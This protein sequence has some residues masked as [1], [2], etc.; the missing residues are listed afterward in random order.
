[1]IYTA[2]GNTSNQD[3]VVRGRYPKVWRAERRRPFE[4]L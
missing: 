2:A 4:A 1:L 3:R